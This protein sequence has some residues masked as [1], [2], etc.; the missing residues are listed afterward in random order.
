[1]RWLRSVYSIVA[2]D[3]DA[4]ILR[5]SHNDSATA[6][7]LNLDTIPCAMTSCIALLLPKCCAPLNPSRSELRRCS[8]QKRLLAP[9]IRK[10]PCQ[11]RIALY[12][13]P[14]LV[15]SGHTQYPQ[16]THCKTHGWL[17]AQL[18]T[19][20]RYFGGSIQPALGQSQPAQAA[21]ARANHAASAAARSNPPDC[22]PLHDGQ[23]H[24]HNQRSSQLECSDT[25]SCIQFLC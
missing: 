15:T 10:R 23:S 25:R 11:F 21:S 9:A 5:L 6:D 20:P 16:T 1:M 22:P 13:K 4:S 17:C 8:G 18:A 2:A 24:T 12:P 19:I 3:G 14:V 7:F